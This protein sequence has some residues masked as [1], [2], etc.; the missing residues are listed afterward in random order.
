M[1]SEWEQQ[2]NDNVN[3]ARKEVNKTK[4]LRCYIDTIIKQLIDDLNKQ[5]VITN[6]AFKQRI[7]ETRRAK[8]EMELQHS[9]VRE[10][11]YLFLLKRNISFLTFR[12][13]E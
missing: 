8:I 11:N 13:I 5:K 9:E 12:I 3:S 2:T 6:E 4:Q 1:V 10:I 7:K